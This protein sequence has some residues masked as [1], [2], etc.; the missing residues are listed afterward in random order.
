MIYNLGFIIG[1]ICGAIA[2]IIDKGSERMLVIFAICIL[3]QI[4]RRFIEKECK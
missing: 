1:L 3:G 2:P 4:I